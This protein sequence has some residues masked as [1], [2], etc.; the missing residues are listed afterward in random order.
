MSGNRHGNFIRSQTE[1]QKKRENFRSR[2]SL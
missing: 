1:Q 2:K